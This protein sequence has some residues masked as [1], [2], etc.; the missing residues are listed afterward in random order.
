MNNQDVDKKSPLVLLRQ[1]TNARIALGAVGNSMP[2]KANLEFQLAHALARDA[3]SIPLNF[4]ALTET[5][6]VGQTLLLQS[7]VENHALYLQRPDLGRILNN[8]A[9]D[10]LKAL[11]A[12]QKKADIVI[13]VADGLSSTA[14]MNHAPALLK[15]LIP[16]LH[17]TGFSIAPV[18]LA[19]YARVA[20]SDQ[21]G[22]ILNAKSSIILIGERPGL[23]SPDSMG[24][25]YTYQPNTNR[26][27]AERNC[28]SNIHLP[29]L[30]YQGAVK[31]LLFIV[32]ESHRLKFSGVDLKDQTELESLDGATISRGNFLLDC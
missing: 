28:I 18:C 15:L 7:K 1:F 32:N 29:G 5:L 24:I 23:S 6:D 19:K 26:T 4:T 20:L 31:K 10:Q 2:L 30:S 21:I 13:T 25:Y 8:Q 9:I 22:E 3:V 14:I 17:Q 11:S 16:A 12:K 27:D